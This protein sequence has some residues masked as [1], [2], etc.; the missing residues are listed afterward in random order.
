[1]SSAARTPDAVQSGRYGARPGTRS[2][3]S[4][5][6]TVESSRSAMPCGATAAG[7]EHGQQLKVGGLPQGLLLAGEEQRF[8]EDF[9]LDGRLCPDRDAE[10]VALGRDSG[11]GIDEVVPLVALA[12]PAPSVPAGSGE[13]S[14]LKRERDRAVGRLDADGPGAGARAA[15]D[16]EIA[17]RVDETRADRGEERAGPVDCVSLADAAEIEADAGLELDRAGV[18]VDGDSAPARDRDQRAAG[19]LACDLVE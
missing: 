9:R 13:G 4:E 15:A 17:A 2:A 11:G 14:V 19:T 18:G 10:E 16:S 5:M 6:R 12:P 1:M 3:A 8:G 7:D